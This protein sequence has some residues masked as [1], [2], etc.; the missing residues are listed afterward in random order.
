MPEHE[1]DIPWFHF[2]FME[3]RALSADLFPDLQ[4]AQAIALKMGDQ[5]LRF[6]QPGDPIRLTSADGE[7]RWTNRTTSIM[8]LGNTA[9]SDVIEGTTVFQFQMIDDGELSEEIH[10]AA[11]LLDH[12][13]TTPPNTPT[14][15]ALQISLVC[16]AD[17]PPIGWPA[18]REHTA[19]FTLQTENGLAFQQAITCRPND[20]L[21]DD[22]D[23]T[24]DA[25]NW[26]VITEV[27]MGEKLVPGAYDLELLIKASYS[28]TASLFF[29]NLQLNPD[30]DEAD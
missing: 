27:I 16:N 19:A 18:D 29:T 23:E 21:D 3:V 15:E 1:Q 26:D 9:P 12:A 30:T 8:F 22:P 17:R 20:L 4:T 10:S 14:V 24:H 2:D 5:V 6:E 7:H 13:A 25:Q 11:R 28:H